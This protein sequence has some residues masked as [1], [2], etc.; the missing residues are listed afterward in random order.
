MIDFER[1]PQNQLDVSR[2]G[3]AYNINVKIFYSGVVQ[4]ALKCGKNNS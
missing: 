2:L 1:A 3:L 4:P